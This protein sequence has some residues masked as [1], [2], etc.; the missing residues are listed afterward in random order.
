MI[1]Y[2]TLAGAVLLAAAA[3]PARM[4]AQ[5][6]A[7]AVDQYVAWLS[8]PSRQW[9]ASAD[10][11]RMPQLATL[12]LLEPGRATPAPHGEISAAGLTLAKIGKSAIPAIAER[13]RLVLLE[14]HGKDASEV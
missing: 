5:N 14:Q 6:A 11:Q 3:A 4:A 10:L 8:D 2:L 7:P 9:L 1:R 12:C 13:L